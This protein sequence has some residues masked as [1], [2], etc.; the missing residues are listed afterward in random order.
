MKPRNG[1]YPRGICVDC[2]GVT[3]SVKGARCRTCWFKHRQPTPEKK[4]QSRVKAQQSGRRFKLKKLYGLEPE[5]VEALYIV[6]K[7]ECGICEKFLIWGKDRICVDHNHKTKHLRL[8]LCSQ[9][10]TGLGLFKEDPKILAKAIR[11]ITLCGT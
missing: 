4:E 10:N 3:S 9:C 2:G 5:E 8:L 6:Q 11:Y 7:G 1:G